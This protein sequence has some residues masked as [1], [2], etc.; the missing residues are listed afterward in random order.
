[1]MCQYDLKV[2]ELV[3][4][5]SALQKFVQ[6]RCVGQ[7]PNSWH[8]W[9]TIDHL[10]GNLQHNMK[11]V[12]NHCS[13]NK[14]MIVS[15]VSLSTNENENR[16]QAFTGHK[17]THFCMRCT[18]RNGIPGI[19][20]YNP[21]I[22]ILVFKPLKTCEAD[23]RTLTLWIAAELHLPSSIHSSFIELISVVVAMTSDSHWWHLRWWWHRWTWWSHRVTAPVHSA[24]P[25]RPCRTAAAPLSPG[26]SAW[27]P[28][29]GSCPSAHLHLWCPL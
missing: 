2:L 12:S 8:A 19:W 26:P 23:L 22:T 11:Q 10:L 14:A 28:S 24:S 7:V 13:Y 5:C 17:V 27:M 3:H 15:G 25:G 18:Y 6:V 16:I 9:F 20:T 1:M 21:V 4:R 29:A